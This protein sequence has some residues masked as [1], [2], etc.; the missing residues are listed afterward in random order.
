MIRGLGAAALWIGSLASSGSIEQGSLALG[1]AGRYEDVRHVVQDTAPTDE[2]VFARLVYNGL[3]PYYAKNWYTDWPKSDRQLIF[4]LQRLTNLR[5]SDH[6]RVIPLND[7]RLFEYPF[8]YTSEPGQ[9][10]LTDEDAGIMREYLERGGFWVVDDFWGSR[11][12]A[13]FE[14]QLEKILPSVE[15]KDIPRDHEILHCFFD[16]DEISQIP[17]LEY[18]YSGTIVEQDGYEPFFRGIWDDRGRLM[19]VINHNT[20]LGDAY[21]HADHPLYPNA[22]SDFA[23]RMALNFIIYS[24]TH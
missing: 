23:Y 11:E 19:V 7:P 3:E 1:Y 9:M 6:E 10:V 21:E 18:V 8:L 24:L 4:G 22:F 2:F 12:W 15:I 20:D 13:H 17:S 14:R 5:I 16:I